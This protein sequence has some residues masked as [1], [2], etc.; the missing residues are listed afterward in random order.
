MALVPC[1][2]ALYVGSSRYLASR[3]ATRRTSQRQ[4]AKRRVVRLPTNLPASICRSKSSNFHRKLP[5]C[6]TAHWAR[7]CSHQMSAKRKPMARASRPWLGGLGCYRQLGQIRRITYSASEI[8]LGC[9]SEATLRDSRRTQN[10]KGKMNNEG[11]QCHTQEASGARWL[12][13]AIVPRISQ[14]GARI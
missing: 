13:S 1:E 14:L 5:A 9:D 7:G 12:L 8:L 3:I 10:D 11:N 2:F 4:V 6:W